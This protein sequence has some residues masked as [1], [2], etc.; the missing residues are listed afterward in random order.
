VAWDIN[1]AK[2]ELVWP[3]GAAQDTDYHGPWVVSI[4][5]SARDALAE[6]PEDRMPEL[7]QRWSGIEELTPFSDVTPELMLEFLR[8]FVRLARNARTSG[9]TIYCWMSL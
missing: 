7:A 3:A 9:D 5:E 2:D 4:G 1:L 8:Q 6:I